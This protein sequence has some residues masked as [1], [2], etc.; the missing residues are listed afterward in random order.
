MIGEHSEFYFVVLLAI[1]GMLIDQF[2]S[3]LNPKLRNKVVYNMHVPS[4][5]D[6]A[7]FL[8]FWFFLFHEGKE[9][10]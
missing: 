5:W 10:L 9:I 2:P 8:G 4:I 6:F 7:N 3:H 1:M